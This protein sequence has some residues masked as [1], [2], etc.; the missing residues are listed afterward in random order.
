MHQ[1]ERYLCEDR[2]E[3]V[4]VVKTPDEQTDE[5][6]IQNQTP[7]SL[8]CKFCSTVFDGPVELHQHERYLCSKNGEISTFSNQSEL[9]TTIAKAVKASPISIPKP[10]LSISPANVAEDDGDDQFVD[11]DGQQYRVRSMITD[12]QLTILKA[13]YNQN[14]RPASHELMDIG[15]KIGFPKRVVQ[16]WFQNMR[17]RDRRRGKV[18]APTLNTKPVQKV[19]EASPSSTTSN[20]VVGTPKLSYATTAGSIYYPG[21]Q[22]GETLAQN[23]PMHARTASPAVEEIQEEPLDLSF[24]SGKSMVVVQPYSPTVTTTQDEDNQVL[25]LS[26]KK[27]DFTEVDSEVKIELRTTPISPITCISSALSHQAEVSPLYASTP[28][29]SNSP[30]QSTT[31]HTSPVTSEMAAMLSLE[32]SFNSGTSLDSTGVEGNRSLMKI[33]GKRTWRQVGHFNFNHS[34]CVASLQYS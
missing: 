21:T 30:V 27:S 34:P 4:M 14:P 24:K 1:H 33:A 3:M 26:M 19:C 5:K 31:H 6:E 13:K 15:T 7:G 2:E 10:V 9:P 23:G 29:I 16:V 20:D 25:N 32:S 28:R 18:I 12:H 11:K 17:A 22:F 8:C